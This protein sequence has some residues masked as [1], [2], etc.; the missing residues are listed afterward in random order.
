MSFFA[1]FFGH[2]FAYKMS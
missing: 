1:Y 2:S